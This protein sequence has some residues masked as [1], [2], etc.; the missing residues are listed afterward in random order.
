[1]KY[2]VAFGG[3]VFCMFSVVAVIL[4]LGVFTMLLCGYKLDRLPSQFWI[5]DL[6]VGC[7][8]GLLAG[9]HSF[10]ASLRPSKTKSIS[11]DHAA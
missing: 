8:L 7:L 2:F 10:R 9:C 1:M 5:Y 6:A 3:L 4:V 11:H